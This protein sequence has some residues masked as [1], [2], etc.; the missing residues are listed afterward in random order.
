[1]VWRIPSNPRKGGRSVSR[2]NATVIQPKLILASFHVI[3]DEVDTRHR[4][5]GE[6][7]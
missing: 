1:M 3:L 2:R 7:G 6:F 5:P 4:V